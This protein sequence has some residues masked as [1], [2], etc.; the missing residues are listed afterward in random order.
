MKNNFT[1]LGLG[2]S[3][4]ASLGKSLS[5]V[6]AK[7][8]FDIALDYNI[9]T[10]DTSDTYGSGDAEKLIGKIVK[11]KRNNFFIISK[12]GYRYLSLPNFFFP[13]N[14]IGK[15]ILQNFKSKKCFK[16]EYILSGI[17]KSLKR[18]KIE[19]LDCFP[20][21]FSLFVAKVEHL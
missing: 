7:K 21:L 6:H 12:V 15:K 14:Q 2:T 8:L 18:L 5:Y 17:E 10:I 13:L 1:K 11:D 16:K 19:N 3:T 4:I 9:R 20:Y